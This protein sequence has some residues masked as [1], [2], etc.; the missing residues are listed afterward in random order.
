MIGSIVRMC[1]SNENEHDC[2]IIDKLR[3]FIPNYNEDMYLAVKKDGT[4]FYG[5]FIKQVYTIGIKGEF[6]GI[7]SIKAGIEKHTWKSSEG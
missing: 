3:R 2:M 5:N 4:T 1:D 7:A 6:W